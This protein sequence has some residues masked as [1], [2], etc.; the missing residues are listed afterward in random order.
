MNAKQEKRGLRILKLLCGLSIACIL[1]IAN[2]RQAMAEALTTK[3]YT[4]S[5]QEG[6][7]IQGIVTDKGGEALIGV[8]VTEKGTTRGTIT[9]LDGKFNI[10]VNSSSSELLFTYIGYNQQGI[11]VGNKTSI[12]V[13]LN[14]DAQMLD[15]LVVVGFGTQKKENLTG[16]VA[17]VDVAKALASKPIT[18]IE[19]GLQGVTPGLSVTYGSGKLGSSAKINIRGSGTIVDG[20]ASGKPLVLVDGIPTDLSLVNPEDVASISVLKDAASASIYGARAAFGVILITTKTGKMSDKVSISYSGNMAFNNPSK[21]VDF[22]DP[23]VELT[24]M[25]AAAG[26]AGRAAEAFGMNF[27]TLLAG[28]QKWKKEYANNRT[29]NEMVY[30]EDWEIIDKRMH[31]YRVWDPH[32]EMLN[33]WTP[34]Q[35]HNLSAQGRMGDKSS[36]MVSLGYSNQ[37]GLMKIQSEDM[38]KYNAN[39]GFNSELTKWLKADFR[40]LASRQN[41]NSPYNYYDNSGYNRAENNGYFGYYMR[42]GSYFPYGQY[43]G[44]KFRHAPGYME[45]ANQNVEQTDYVRLN[46]SLTAQLTKKLQ[47]ITEYSIANKNINHKLNGGTVDLWDFWAPL[48]SN[49]VEDMKLTRLV[50]AGDLHDR[51]AAAKSLDQ[52]Q[53]FN[54]YATYTES[55]NK[56]HNFKAMAGTNIEWNDFERSYSERRALMDKD[57]PEFGLATGQQF[58]SSIYDGFSPLHSQYAIAGL[59][60]RLNYDYQGRYLLEVN[61]RYDGSSRFP[62]N[63]QWAFFPSASVGYRVSEEAFMQSTKSFMNDLK[64]RASVGSIGNQNIAANAFLPVM[65]ST[66]ANWVTNGVMT[67]SVD[68][69]RV[70]DPGLSWEKVVTYD[71]G[72]DVQFLNGMFGVSF[73]WYQRNTSGMLAPGKSLPDVFGADAPLTNA[74]DLRTR[75]YELSLDFN[76]PINKNISVFANLSLADYQSVVTKW[77]NVSKTLGLMYEGRKLGE[78]WGL[79]TDRLYQVDDFTNGILNDGYASQASLQRSGFIFGPGDI[80]YKD[81]NNDGK[82]DAGKRTLDDHGDLKIIGNTTPRYQYGIRLG[83]NGYGFDLD[84]FFQGVGKRDFWADS[85]LILPLYNRTDALYGNQLDYWTP[86]NTDAYF[87]NPFPGSS[88]SALASGTTG[89]NNFVTQSKYMLDMSYLRLKNI[90]FGYTLPARLS[91][92]AYMEKARIY[93]SAQNVAEFVSDKLPV[94]PEIDEKEA[95]WGRTYPYTRTVSFGLQV[96]F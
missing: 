64:L 32:K 87:P 74:G 70:V 96:T 93:F 8:S 88:A 79:E 80:K 10:N 75:G 28:V 77:N 47:V 84:I 24:S 72:A 92:K 60:G 19:K 31:F 5:Q 30:G 82:I 36:F 42:W 41:Y 51:V 67:P 37:E 33:E 57:K 61:G 66:T 63:S 45:N 40:V 76:Y 94:D 39:I 27:N 50:G 54:A 65:R 52:T 59:F 17:S 14:E 13:Q 7:R 22:A 9:D 1:L 12:S 90:T 83:G 73:D 44:K 62:S 48:S 95:A 85:D 78:I 71:I 89:S 56:S 2:S 53:V 38:A 55:I 11:V 18:N 35:S 34:Q 81:L 23:E 21:L 20:V 4:S 43:D 91:K 25:I 86:Q 49:N 46:G 6:L 15:E 58:S 3:G 16:A 29:S 26:R 69:P 68:L